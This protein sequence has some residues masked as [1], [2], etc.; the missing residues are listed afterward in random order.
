[1]KTAQEIYNRLGDACGDMAYGQYEMYK[2]DNDGG[3]FDENTKHIKKLIKEGV[4]DIP[5]RL[6]DDYYNDSELLG[7]LIGDQV[8]DASHGSKKIRLKLLE[9]LREIGH[10]AVREACNK[11]IRRMV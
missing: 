8:Y 2:E 1:M 4:T 7:D 5:G 6:A 11:I 9:E 3:F 10:G